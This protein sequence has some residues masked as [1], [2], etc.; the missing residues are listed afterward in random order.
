MRFFTFLV[1]VFFVSAASIGQETLDVLTLS[2]RY[3][4]PQSY[5]SIYKSKAKEYGAMASLVA[6]IKMNEKS[7]WYNSVNYFYFHVGNDEDTPPE[8]MNP[9]DVHGI[10]PLFGMAYPS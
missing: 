9:I 5:D 1:F 3:G 10:I 7:I 4:F 2:G 6:P 8:I